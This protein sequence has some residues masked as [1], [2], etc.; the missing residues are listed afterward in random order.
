MLTV[1][2]THTPEVSKE[3]INQILKLLEKEKNRQLLDFIYDEQQT[4]ENQKNNIEQ[5]LEAAHERWSFYSYIYG[6]K[7]LSKQDFWDIADSYRNH[8]KAVKPYKPIA[9]DNIVVVLSGMRDIENWFSAYNIEKNAI[10]VHTDDWENFLDCEPHYPIAHQIAENVLQLLIKLDYHNT[11]LFE[12]HVHETAIGCMNDFCGNRSD[13][14]LKMRTAD[15]CKDCFQFAVQRV[16]PKMVTSTL[17]IFERIRTKMLTKERF[18]VKM[19][20]SKIRIDEKN[21][22]IYLQDFANTKLNLNA[23]AKALY[24]FLLANQEPVDFIKL[25]NKQKELLRRIYQFCSNRND[26][27]DGYKELYN[28]NTTLSVEISR[29]N[30]KF[31]DLVGDIPNILE[32][33]KIQPADY[34]TKKIMLPRHYVIFPNE[35][36]DLLVKNK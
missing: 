29:T 1:H 2:I 14:R 13:I 3:L 30:K 10:F 17:A 8:Y 15:I 31:G 27:L 16:N 36:K 26:K 18:L 19:T 33:Y 21:F 32:Q 34:G 25:N 12:K 7:F 22:D 6:Q 4:A 28:D 20:P 35:I 24:I 11:E 23:R 5:L 9:K